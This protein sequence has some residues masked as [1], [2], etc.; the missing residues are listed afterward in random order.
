MGRSI[1][2]V[3]TC[4]TLIEQE[5]DRVTSQRNAV[6]QRPGGVLGKPAQLVSCDSL[7]SRQQYRPVNMATGAVASTNVDSLSAFW[8]GLQVLVGDVESAIQSHLV[9]ANLWRRCV[10]SS[11]PHY[12]PVL[13]QRGQSWRYARSL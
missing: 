7:K 13:K 9:F 12:D 10:L 5:T 11:H 1:R 8:P 6:H 4:F 3:N 2:K